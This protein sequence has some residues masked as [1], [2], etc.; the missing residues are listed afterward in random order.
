MTNFLSFEDQTLIFDNENDKT[1]ISNN[2][3]L[4]KR[5]PFKID[6]NKFQGIQVEDEAVK[7]LT[8]KM[9][10]N[11]ELL[12]LSDIT[13]SC[14]GLEAI[15][16]IKETIENLRAVSDFEVLELIFNSKVVLSFSP[17]LFKEL[18]QSTEHTVFDLLGDKNYLIRAYMLI[19]CTELL[20]TKFGEELLRID[21]L[22]SIFKCC[23]KTELYDISGGFIISF[24]KSNNPNASNIF[25][26]LIDR[27]FVENVEKNYLNIFFILEQ[28][29]LDKIF[30][31]NL[32]LYMNSIN[33]MYFSF[34][35]KSRELKD[36]NFVG[37][38]NNV[39]R[40]I[41][42]LLSV[43]EN[44]TIVMRLK[45]NNVNLNDYNSVEDFLSQYI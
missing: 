7:L 42:G 23:L 43:T 35:S 25:T 45:A 16:K 6:L 44:K 8:D 9:N 13:Y 36:D 15:S 17:Y 37:F 5:V 12:S 4:I 20:H 24:F 29:F 26:Y 39:Y 40:I 22:K 27:I 18:I 10:K 31:D 34:A 41:V 21:V 14:G 2:S 32:I 33:K 19:L 28:L 30:Q 1:L 11:L 3:K 38:L